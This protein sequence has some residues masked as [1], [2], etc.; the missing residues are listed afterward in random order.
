MQPYEASSEYSDITDVSRRRYKQLWTGFI[1]PSYIVV[2][3]DA[4]SGHWFT[5]SE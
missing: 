2:S 4:E 1:D 5:R 3:S